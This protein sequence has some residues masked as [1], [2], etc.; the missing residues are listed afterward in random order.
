MRSFIPCS[1]ASVLVLTTLGCAAPPSK[2]LDVRG[3][4]L[5]PP[6][7]AE[8]AAPLPDDSI[9]FYQHDYFRGDV[10]RVEN[11]T[12]QPAGRVLEPQPGAKDRTSS[13][14]WNLPPG[15]L[16]VLFEDA[17]GK[18]DQFVIWGKGE[19]ANVAPWDFNDKVSR[20]AWYSAGTA[21]ASRVVG[22]V[23]LL[24]PDARATGALP[25]GVVELYDDRDLGGDLATLGPVTTLDAGEYHPVPRG[26]RMTSLRWNLPPNVIVILYDNAGG[27]GKQ[28]AVWGHGEYPTV[29]DRDFND[30]ASAWAWY[31]IAE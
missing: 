11:V 6:G 26:D 16:V 31:R 21:S 29:S 1:L 23:G 13:L 22:N 5:R 24:P 10:V 3:V 27:T 25:V 17:G 8:L 2:T 4:S 28:M 15:V 30:R 18:G 19:I 9:Y 7:A 12:A 20:W 14:R